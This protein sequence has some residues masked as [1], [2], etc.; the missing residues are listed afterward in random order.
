[1]LRR[2]GFTPRAIHPYDPVRIIRGALKTLRPQRPAIGGMGGREGPSK[3]PGTRHAPAKPGRAS[4]MLGGGGA[5]VREVVRAVFY[6]PP[7]LRLL[8]HML[9]V[10]AVKR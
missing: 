3:P 7:A 5:V 6:T 10:V 1:V 8:G 9:L 2:H 4:V